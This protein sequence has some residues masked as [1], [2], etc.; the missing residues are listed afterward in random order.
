M[1]TSMRIKTWEVEENEKMNFK[2]IIMAR[3]V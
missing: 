2:V 1:F 3:R